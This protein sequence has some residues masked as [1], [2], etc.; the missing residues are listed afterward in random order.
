[1]AAPNDDLFVAVAADAAAAATAATEAF[2]C[3]CW[4]WGWGGRGR[5]SA[6]QSMWERILRPKMQY[7]L[8]HDALLM[9]N[10]TD[11]VEKRAGEQSRLSTSRE[12]RRGHHARRRARA[13][14]NR[15]TCKNQL[16]R[17]KCAVDKEE[18]STLRK[19]F[20]LHLGIQ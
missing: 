14:I 5:P 7:S 15:S 9:D 19:R 6:R 2:F 3:G 17:V 11:T 4:G 10:F 13:R 8:A 16:S 20:I 18:T 12:G 1:M